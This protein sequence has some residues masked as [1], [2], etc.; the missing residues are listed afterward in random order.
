M[1]THLLDTN[2]LIL[3][4]RGRMIALDLLEQYRG[5]DSAGISVT[6]RT[7][8]L[9]GMRP[10]EEELTMALLTSLLNLPVTADVADRAGRLIYAAARRG[11][12]TSFPDAL[13]AATALEHDLIVVTTNAKHFEELGVSVRQI[14]GE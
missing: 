10:Y 1:L 14:A 4:L 8:I 6:T 11:A 13:I 12:Q 3:A 2:V 5:R 7:E 9:A